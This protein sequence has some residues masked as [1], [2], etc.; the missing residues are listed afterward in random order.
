MGL[1]SALN[2]GLT[3]LL[4]HQKM[5]EVTGNNIANVNTPGY[6]R[7]SATLSPQPAVKIQGLYFGQGVNVES[8]NREYDRFIS[9]RL[10]DQSDIL[11]R[12]SAKSGPLAEIERVIGIGENSLA[13]DI[14]RFFGAWHDLSQNPSGTV[15]REQVIYMGENLLDSFRSTRAELVSVGQNIN[16]SLNAEVNG[17]NLK[18]REIAALNESIKSKETLGHAANTD[19]DRR[20]LLI[21][22]L[23]NTI[24]IQTYDI[25]GNQVGVQLP[26]GIPLVQGSTAFEFQSYYA[27]DTLRFQVKSGDLALQAERSNFGGEFRGL[28]DVRDGFIPELTQDLNALQYALV[29]EVNARHEAG[30]GLDGLTGR[31]FFS[32]PESWRS[33]TGSNDPEAL[34]FSTGTLAINGVDV[35]LVDGDNSLN[36]LRDAINNADAGVL[37]SVVYDGATYHLSVTPET[38]GMEPLI[39]GLVSSVGDPVVFNHE[40]GSDASA[41]A[42]TSVQA[43]AS[44]GVTQGA[45]GD[46][47]NALA[48]HSLKDSPIMGGKESFIDRYGRMAATVGTETRRNTMAHGGAED[49]MNQLQNLREAIVGVSIDEEMI[50]LTMFQK[51]FEAAARFV[52]TVDEMM[53]TIIGIKR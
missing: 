53:T 36:G 46:N 23:S 28:L 16:D 24:G 15:E 19:L 7:Q 14:E 47:E 51:G 6:S 34:V 27:G 39:T 13:S 38:E 21:K 17:I 49:T 31:S 26:G 2:S 48:I 9:G 22:E 33:D 5:V 10:F 29:T 8:V 40:E 1:I 18:L 43:V 52:S 25:G 4:S 42:I 12:E 11:G 45:P 3:S 41:V 44:A 50:N 37:A 20:E 32:G 35:T 30:Y